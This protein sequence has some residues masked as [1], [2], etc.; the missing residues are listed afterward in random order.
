MA[1]WSITPSSRPGD[2]PP[3]SILAALAVL[4]LLASA[5][6]PAALVY[7]LSY[8]PAS[9]GRVRVEIEF[10][11]DA[12]AHTLVMPRAI[13][14]GYA[15]VDYDRY[16]RDV[17]AFGA[18]GAALDV[19]RAPEGPRW[20]LGDGSAAVRSVRY[21]V[22]LESMEREVLGASDASKA[23]SGYVGLLGYSVFAFPDGLEGL[24]AR[25]RVRAPDD[26]PVFLTL[27]PRAE[28]A[29]G[30]AEAEAR[31]FYAL[32][33]SQVAM[34]PDLE[35]LRLEAAVPLFVIQYAE[36]ASDIGAMGKLSAEAL[37]AVAAYFG[38]VPFRHYTVH[39]EFLE[40]RSPEHGYNFSM[41]HLESSTIF[42]DTEAA[43]GE[44]TIP[45]RLA[46]HR[47]NLAHHMA[48]SWIPKRW[49]AEGYFPWSWELSPVIDS[50][51]FSEGWGQYIAAAA[52]AGPG[53]LGEGYREELVNQRFRAS[54]ESAPAF[55]REASLV[56]VS[57]IASTRYSEDFRTGRSAFSRGGMMAYEMDQA[58]RAA[59][60]GRKSLRD[61]LRRLLEEDPRRPL[62]LDRLPD[63]CRE[64]TGV[65]VDAIYRRWLAPL[66]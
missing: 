16:L 40:P 56:Q 1:I 52:L 34:G 42:F 45:S 3:M 37:A 65:D 15:D 9:P 11:A 30:I 60:G 13:P 14:M 46:R 63:L 19:S 66:R 64:A 61:L 50:I 27:D 57:R 51:W 17:E 36:R 6:A 2:G 35:V 49:A 29:R 21:E 10:P 48:H 4:N 41:E 31:D 25:L 7:Q 26:W 18:D 59:T 53:G 43:I 47:Y 33:D 44:Q 62:D 8:S 22:D 54:L 58:I 38:A 5:P 12:R 20:Q 28:P 24:P 23:R 32:A 55:L 39:V